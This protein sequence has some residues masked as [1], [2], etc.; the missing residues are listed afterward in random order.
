MASLFIGSA[1]LSSSRAHVHKQFDAYGKC[2]VDE[3]VRECK[4]F[5]IHF[6]KMSPELIHLLERIQR[7]KY[8]SIPYSDQHCWKVTMY[9]KV[10]IT[11]YVPTKVDIT[12]NEGYKLLI[13]M[14]YVPGQGLGKHGT[15]IKK[16]IEIRVTSGGIGYIR[17]GR[18]PGDPIRF[19][20]SSN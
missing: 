9:N 20:K 13:K 6:E 2:K 12:L 15:G 14:G 17:G 3:V 7:E 8:V 10:K 1:E 4:R 16:P 18:R 11:H 19:V 5:Y